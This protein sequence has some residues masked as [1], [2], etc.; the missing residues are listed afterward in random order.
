MDSDWDIWRSSQFEGGERRTVF[1]AGNDAFG[2]ACSVLIH[3]DILVN[4]IYYGLGISGAQ[5][6]Q[7]NRVDLITAWNPGG[8][9]DKRQ[10][11]LRINDGPVL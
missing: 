7:R 3:R 1:D 11:G 4:P 8:I 6:S 2:D 10:S 9:D 5:H